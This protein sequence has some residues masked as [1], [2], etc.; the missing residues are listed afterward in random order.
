M[1]SSCR[2]RRRGRPRWSGERTVTLPFA[3]SPFSRAFTF[4]YDRAAD[5]FI[6]PA[7]IA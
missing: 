6:T 4:A 1:T 5:V 7:I 3:S 2:G